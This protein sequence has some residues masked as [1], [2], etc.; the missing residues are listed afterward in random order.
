MNESKIIDGLNDLLAKNY[1]AEKGFK[2]AA[3]ETN[4]QVL[5]ALYRGKA[6][7]RYNFG[8]QIK[9]ILREME[10]EIDKGTS[11]MGDLHRAWINFKTFFAVDKE[12]AILEEIENGEEASLKDYNEFLE[13]SELPDSI[14]RIITAQRNSVLHTLRRVDE[15]EEMYG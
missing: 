6:S 11:T 8:H 10:G 15:L 14:R 9:D 2:K 7:Q 1:D 5:A 13:N 4:N 12:E 3:E